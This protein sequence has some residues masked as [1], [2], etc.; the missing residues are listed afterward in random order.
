MWPRKYFSFRKIIITILIFFV[1][2]FISNLMEAWADFEPHKTLVQRLPKSQLRDGVLLRAEKDIDVYLTYDNC[3][4]QIP[5]PVTFENL[6]FSWDMVISRPRYEMYS[7][8]KRGFIPNTPPGTMVKEQDSYILYIIYKGKK[9]IVPDEQTARD[10]RT[11]NWRSFV[12]VWPKGLMD[13]FPRG[14]DIPK[15]E[16]WEEHP[17]YGG[18]CTWYVSTKRKIPWSGNAK[19]WFLN[20]Q[21]AGFLTGDSPLPGSI[22][23]T[24]DSE[25]GHVALVETLTCDRD[26]KWD[27]FQ[28]SEM[29][30]GSIRDKK[31][32]KTVNFNKITSRFFTKQNPPNQN[33]LIGYIY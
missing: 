12:D 31:L 6:G 22:M 23:V 10:L 19:D 7:Y 8:V 20:A 25:Y 13:L 14:G 15:S 32:G 11:D 33:T 18:Y 5:N 16:S 30:W 27:T 28:V 29:N 3:L 9:Y 2:F 21:K 26:G 24:S 4:Y 1:V 17:F